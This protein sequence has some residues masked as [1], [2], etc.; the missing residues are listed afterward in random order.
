MY[1]VKHILAQVAR[2]AAGR[3]GACI[4]RQHAEQQRQAG[5][6]DQRS[7]EAGDY[8]HTASRLDLVDKLCNDK[9]DDAFHHHLQRNKNWRKNGR[10]FE[11]ADTF[12]KLPIHG[13]PLL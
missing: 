6:S 11:F 4:A 10:P 2:K 8:A 9:R 7:S 3:L 5:H 12:Y 13:F 1:L